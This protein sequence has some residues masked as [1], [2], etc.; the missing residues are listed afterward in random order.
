VVEGRTWLD[1]SADANGS[2]L[3]R[4]TL[5]MLVSTYGRSYSRVVQLAGK[6]PD[7]AERLCPQN[8]EIVAQLH[9][10]VHEEMAVSLQDVLLRRT[11]IGTSHCQGLDCA[12]AIGQR[13]AALLGWTPRRLS[14]EL[15][16][17]EAHVARSHRFKSDQ[18]RP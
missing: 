13:M 17:Y 16:A 5:E 4:A 8:P 14:A 10:A 7:G 3:E 2:G 11:G 15:D 6:V 9:L 12:E 18:P 1:V